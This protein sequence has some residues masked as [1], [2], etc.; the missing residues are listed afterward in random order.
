MNWLEIIEVVLG[1]VYGVQIFFVLKELSEGE[2]TKKRNV[3]IDLVPFF[4]VYRLLIDII[5]FF[6]ELCFENMVDEFKK[7]KW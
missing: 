1:F 2:Y 6:Y 7:L 3:L 4:F 5:Q